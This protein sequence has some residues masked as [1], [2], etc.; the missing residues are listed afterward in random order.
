[1]FKIK[2][3]ILFTMVLAMGALITNNDVLA[4]CEDPECFA[5]GDCQI[6]VTRGLNGEFPIVIDSSNES[7]YPQYFPDPADYVPTLPFTVFAY[8]FS[9][10]CIYSQLAQALPNPG[11][12]CPNDQYDI[13]Y[14]SI[15][16]TW[17]SA[18]NGDSDTKW[19]QG[20]GSTRV[21][22]S[23]PNTTSFFFITTNNVSAHPAPIM[24]KE[25]KKLYYG[26]LLAPNCWVPPPPVEVSEVSTSTPEGCVL[27]VK[28]T[29][30]GPITEAFCPDP[31][32]G[33]MIPK[34]VTEFDITDLYMGIPTT[35]DCD[36]EFDGKCLNLEPFK[37]LSDKSFGR[38]GENSTGWYYWNGYWY[39]YTY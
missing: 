17:Q 8:D 31:D 1:M 14:K 34:T 23:Q 20:D 9:S 26:T 7:D 35:G 19:Y 6:N 32:T 28:Q 5:A 39:S 16:S 38:V 11:L 12:Y 15:P 10:T 29:K 13:L 36:C 25:G 18:G 2:S 4:Q 3:L 27:T 22:E 24:V 37:F 33:E 30:T 21:L